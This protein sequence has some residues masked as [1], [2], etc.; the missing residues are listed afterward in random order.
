M[1]VELVDRGYA[2]AQQHRGND[3]RSKDYED[4]LFAEQRAKKLT[5]GIWCPDDK[6]PIIHINDLSMV[7][8]FHNFKIEWFKI[9]RTLIKQ[10]NF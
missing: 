5:K 6:A 2:E 9:K 1:A 7:L 10:N 3:L 8:F 4:I